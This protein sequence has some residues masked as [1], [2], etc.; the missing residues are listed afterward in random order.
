[1]NIWSK[2]GNR[3]LPFQKEI[4]C[5]FTDTL[6]LCCLRSKKGADSSCTCGRYC[7]ML[8]SVGATVSA[9]NQTS[10]CTVVGRIKGSSAINL[11]LISVTA[12]LLS[13][14]ASSLANRQLSFTCS[15]ISNQKMVWCVKVWSG[16]S[17]FGNLRTRGS[18]HISQGSVN[19]VEITWAGNLFAFLSTKRSMGNIF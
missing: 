2:D 9:R 13:Q 11:I 17:S 14:W 15:Y 18:W 3:N 1:M 6:P 5:L 12:G 19:K 8:Y 16:Y 4:F 10:V 7:Y